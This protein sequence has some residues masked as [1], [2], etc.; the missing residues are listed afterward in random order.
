M[1][2]SSAFQAL[3]LDVIG[4][5]AFGLTVNCQTDVNDSFLVQCQKFFRNVSAR[6]SHLL[7][8]ASTYF[9]YPISH[10]CWKTPSLL[11]AV[12][13]PEIDSILCKFRHLSAFGAAEDWLINNLKKIVMQR[14]KTFHVRISLLQSNKFH[15]TLHLTL[16]GLQWPTRRFAVITWTT[17]TWNWIRREVW[18]WN[19]NN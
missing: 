17:A 5:C 7:R 18:E 11:F 6:K 15:L 16:V 13:F 12:I 8:L 9:F 2:W 3:T 4:Q 14:K 10:W 19:G 1:Q